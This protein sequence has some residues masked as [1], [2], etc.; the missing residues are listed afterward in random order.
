ML[1]YELGQIT[2]PFWASVSPSLKGV[3]EEKVFVKTLAD[4]L[5]IV[6]TQ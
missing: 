3:C 5:I 2:Y 6:G 4:S 1:I